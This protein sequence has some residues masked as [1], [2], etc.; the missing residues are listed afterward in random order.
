VAVSVYRCRMVVA[1][2]REWHEDL[3]WGVLDSSETPGGCWTHYSAIDTPVLHREV[4]AEISQY[5]IVAVGE[6]VELTW[7]APG[8]DGFG[9]RAR[10]RHAHLTRNGGR[11]AI[12]LLVGPVVAFLRVGRVGSRQEGTN[13]DR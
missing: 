8:Q 12:A 6:V 11:V 1:V 3:G 10:R 5:K 7:E 2:V 9:F 4:G 13:G